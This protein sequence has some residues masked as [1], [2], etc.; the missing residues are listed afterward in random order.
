MRQNNKSKF[1]KF[2]QNKS[3]NEIHFYFQ[4]QGGKYE[5]KGRPNDN[6][7]YILDKFIQKENLFNFN[8][9]GALFN[10]NT[11]IKEKTLAE[12]NIKDNSCIII[13]LSNE[14]SNISEYNPKYNSNSRDEDELKEK[15]E[16]FDLESLFSIIDNIN[17]IRNTQKSIY[18]SIK[19]NNSS[20][21]ISKMH[22]HRLVY[23]LSNNIWDCNK[24]K[25]SNSENDPK[26]YCSLCD[27]NICNNCIGNLKNIL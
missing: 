5:V 23:L 4:L 25:K 24:C 17:D 22:N 27:Y 8:L 13:L 9:K 20:Q 10:G 15:E 11:I 16:N 19:L 21:I 7:Q 1:N 26:Y 6:F 18:E 12:N 14:E 3:I 2:F